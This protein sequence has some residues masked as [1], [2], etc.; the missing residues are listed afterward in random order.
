MKDKLIDG[1]LVVSVTAMG[2]G[3]GLLV[4]GGIEVYRFT[5][6]RKIYKK[7][8]EKIIATFDEMQKILYGKVR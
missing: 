1:L 7:R 2:I 6:E 8:M 4:K 3:I 5:Q